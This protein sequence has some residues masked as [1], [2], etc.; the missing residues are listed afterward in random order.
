MYSF[1]NAPSKSTS[2]KSAGICFE[3][4]YFLL[5]FRVRVRANLLLGKDDDDCREKIETNLVPN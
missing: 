2:W 5:M 1:Y 3:P 4:H